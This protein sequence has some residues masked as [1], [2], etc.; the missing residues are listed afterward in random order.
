MA[1]SNEYTSNTTPN[2]LYDPK[3]NYRYTT[4]TY[5]TIRSFK[6]LINHLLS[7]IRRY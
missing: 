4:N 5:N 2:D 1:N 3:Y 7:I 6:T